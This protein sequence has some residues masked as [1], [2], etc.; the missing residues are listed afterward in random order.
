M[1][2]CAFQKIY[3]TI[4]KINSWVYICIFSFL[5]SQI[6]PEISQL[7]KYSNILSFALLLLLHFTF[8]SRFFVYIHFLLG[9]NLSSVL[10]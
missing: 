1:T 4:K 10:I 3:K 6:L 9:F 8:F 5:N 7:F 2:V